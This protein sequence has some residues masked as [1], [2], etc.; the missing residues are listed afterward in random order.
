MRVKIPDISKQIYKEDVLHTIESR[1]SII[2][3]LWV[4]HQM[5]WCNRAYSTFKDHDKFLIIS[6]LIKQTLDFYSRNFVK[7]NYEKFFSKK[8]L[9]LEKFNVT[10]VSK[11]LNIPKET[12]RRK[13]IELEKTSVIKKVKKKLIIDKSAFEFVKPINTIVS[14]SRTLSVISKLLWDEKNLT[15]KLDSK[16]LEKVIKNNFSYVWK[17]WYELQIPMVLGYKEFFN[18]IECFHIWG[19]CVVN[20]H[21][22]ARK[23]GIDKMHRL[24]FIN[25]FVEDP[26]F[27]LNAMSISDVTG[28]PRATVIR[29]LE[30]L[31]EKNFLLI[32]TKKHYK[33]TGSGINKL[34]PVQKIVLNKLSNFSTKIFNLAIL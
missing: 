17:I 30:E 33:L 18:D 5:E 12:V 31:V 10:D 29:K 3:P 2:G 8:F 22:H 6:Y 24:E 14:L 19:T 27:G 7:L 25:F 26:K 16:K 13:I 20:Q 21:F 28:I 4:N 11:N 9:E 32:D 1:Y 15:K 34:L 23:N